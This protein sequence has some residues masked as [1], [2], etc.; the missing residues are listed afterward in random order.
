MT[1]KT[2]ED[3]ILHGDCRKLLPLE[4]ANS[5][6]LI[7]TSPPYADNRKSTYKGVRIDDY[8]EWFLPISEELRR[9]LKP[10]GSFVLNIKE[11]VV[12]GERSTHVIELILALRQQGWFWTEEY[13]WHKRNSYPGKWPN[14]FR[15]GWE[16]CLHFTKQRDFK[17]YQDAV[18][19]P[20]GD[21]APRRL[22][23]LSETDKSRD[24]SR[25]GSPFSK[26]VANW[27]GKT[28]VYPDN[29]IHIATE[30]ANRGH[31][32]AFPIG[33]PDYFVK[34]F[35]KRGDVVLDP[36][37]GSGTTALAAMQLGRHYV[38][39]ELNAAYRKAACAA[40][41]AAHDETL[42]A[43]PRTPRRKTNF[44]RPVTQS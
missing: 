20:I 21:W 15:D 4:S 1:K 13:I 28:H 29:V 41:A 8:V 5:V 34:L 9:V 14:R 12:N 32:A 44:T 25:V 26:R 27:V 10:R 3:R 18:K 42:T 24:A 16:R 11:S 38:G 39:M 6:D 17:M 33:L 35:T 22:A 31:S 40:V 36:F 2:I 43:T 7:V 37:L 19:V 30:S 23:R